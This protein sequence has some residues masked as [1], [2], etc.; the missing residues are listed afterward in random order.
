MK[1][2]DVYDAAKYD[3]I[4][5]PHLELD[6]L[7]EL[8][9]ISKCLAEG[10][11]P[12]EYG[13]H[14]HSKLRIGGTIA[15]SLLV[16]LL[17]D[18]FS[19]REESFDGKPQTYPDL[20][21][22]ND[23]SG[24]KSGDK[25]GDRSGGDKAGDKTGDNTG[26]KTGDKVGDKVGAAGVSNASSGIGKPSGD[27]ADDAN[28]VSNNSSGGG[29]EGA[30]G[31]PPGGVPLTVAVAVVVDDDAASTASNTNNADADDHAAALKEEEEDELSTTRLNHRYASTVG[32]QSPQR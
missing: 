12:N 4:H 29:G 7:E 21:R 27:G 32:V 30:G 17:T 5:N 1:V 25:S 15:H 10:V 13:T 19:T 9:R 31:A 2:P 6:G 24:D 23:R 18:M 3:A 16:K 26:D 14:P 8:Y 22:Q 28:V 11:V 20:D